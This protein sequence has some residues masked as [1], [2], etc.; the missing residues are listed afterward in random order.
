MI[1]F[2][3]SMKRRHW[4]AAC[5]RYRGY[6]F[7]WVHFPSSRFG[8]KVHKICHHVRV[9][10]EFR[11]ARRC[12]KHTSAYKFFCRVAYNLSSFKILKTQQEPNLA[13]HWKCQHVDLNYSRASGSTAELF[14]AASECVIR[15]PTDWTVVRRNPRK[16]GALC[17]V[18]YVSWQEFPDWFAVLGLNDIAIDSGTSISYYC[19]G[20]LMC[21]WQANVT[22]SSVQWGCNLT[23][24]C[25]VLVHPGALVFGEMAPVQWSSNIQTVSETLR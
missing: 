8:P 6:A 9:F 7:L 12:K 13:R 21:Q 2:W 3:S 11:N 14:A 1:S 4:N 25:S 24:H 16:W 20:S 5:S 15:N 17:F 10:R 18:L 19:Y 22:N 23:S